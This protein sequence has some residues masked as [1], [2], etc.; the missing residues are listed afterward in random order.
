MV[1]IIKHL[2]NLI[3]PPSTKEYHG[4]VTGVRSIAYLWII[5]YHCLQI[6]NLMLPQFDEYL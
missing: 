3:T 2:N 1:D 4:V 5:I 6:G